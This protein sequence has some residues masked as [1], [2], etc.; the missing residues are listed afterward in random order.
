MSPGPSMRMGFANWPSPRPRMLSYLV[1]D[2]NRK[3]KEAM[4]ITAVGISYLS[5]KTCA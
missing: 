2:A 5:P 4:R 3:V 1:R